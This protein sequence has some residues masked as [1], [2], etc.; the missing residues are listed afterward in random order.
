MPLRIFTLILSAAIAFSLPASAAKLYKWVDGNGQ[1]HYSQLPPAGQPHQKFETSSLKESKTGDQ[2]C[3]LQARDL[4]LKIAQALREGTTL[5]QIHQLFPVSTYP[6]TVELANFVASKHSLKLDSLTISKMA[7]DACI[8][9]KLQ[10]C[11]VGG[12]SAGASSGGS[13]TG[14]LIAKGM[15]LTNHHVIEQCR[16]IKVG[17]SEWEAQ[18]IAKDGAS[19]LALLQSSIPTEIFATF[20]D[21][22]SIDLGESILAVGYPLRGVLSSQLNITLGNVSSLAG[23]LNDQTVFQLTAPIQPGNSGGPILDESGNV[24][25]MVV[26]KL[27]DMRALRSTGSL[28]QNV[29]F[30]IQPLIVQA[31]IEN[32]AID[33]QRAPSTASQK[34]TDISRAA[35]QY[36]VPVMCEK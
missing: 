33:Y 15:I 1:V 5:P 6:Q 27:N 17:A 3:C 13:G 24:V 4:S 22:H 16:Q 25:G 11:R 12:N 23:P 10:A 35:Q 36:T 31:F 32:H 28:P 18:V 19:D 30:A 14:F 2:Q 34:V 26:S 7:Y 9:S 29:N 21:R 8:S 20:R